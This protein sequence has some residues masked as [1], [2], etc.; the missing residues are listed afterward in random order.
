M[1]REQKQMED[2]EIESIT[3]NEKFRDGL[4]KVQRAAEAKNRQKVEDERK[5]QIKKNKC[6]TKLQAI[7]RSIQGRKK[8][9]IYMCETQ[10]ERAFKIKD[11]TKLYIAI[12][13]M[14]KL[15][16]KSKAL[17][18]YKKSASAVILDKLSE[19]HIVD[20]LQEAIRSD[21]DYLLKEALS[22]AESSKMTFLPQ[23]ATAKQRIAAHAQ[24]KAGL[25]W[26][27]KELNLANTV[28]RLLQSVDYIRRLIKEASLKSLHHEPV[29]EEAL[30]RISKIKR[31]IAVR[32]QMRIACEIASKSAM[33]AALEER[34]KYIN[35]FGE[36]I[37]EEELV[38]INNM[39]RMLD[40]L[41]R[42]E[43]DSQEDNDNNDPSDSE[44]EDE[45][46]N[47]DP[48]SET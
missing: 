7:A 34:K 9:Q 36:A 40:L 16:V 8:G 5:F 21:S 11:Q 13:N 26:L 33:L 19:A 30:F 43:A 18:S 35:V 3:E 44:G 32:D 37:F 1:A 48:D 28:P 14:Q 45:G 17:S 10:F 31:L 15:G 38:A 20:Q 47:D 25:A 42:M 27:E 24:L 4:Y 2:A 41:P 23:V 22:H 12:K 6:A 29:C 39:I 46:D